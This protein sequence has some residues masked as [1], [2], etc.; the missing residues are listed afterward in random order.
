MTPTPPAER[1]RAAL[2]AIPS[3][4]RNLREIDSVA[5]LIR[6]APIEL[7]HTCGFD[8]AMVSLVEESAC[9]AAGICMPADA[10]LAQRAQE[11]ALDHPLPLGADTL[12]GEMLRR[13]TPLL[14]TDARQNP[15]VWRA[16][17][18]LVSTTSYVAAPVLMGQRVVALLHADQGDSGVATD[19]VDLNVLAG[20][21]EGLGLAL[22]HATAR[23]ELRS[24]RRHLLTLGGTQKPSTRDHLE[25]ENDSALGA[26]GPPGGSAVATMI[27]ADL[28]DL[29]TRRERDVFRLMVEGASNTEIAARLV[30]TNATVKS[31][32]RAILR[33]LNAATRVQAVARYLTAFTSADERGVP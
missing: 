12:E 1:H 10:E 15:R 24:L 30:V 17:A 13:R 25:T 20:F 21:A 14:V 2:G 27:E 9:V 5:Q 3:A 19:E 32:V 11:F 26:A 23:A 28:R 6:R 29:L 4:L 33:K 8:R 18:E 16:F 7:C 22:R 31:H